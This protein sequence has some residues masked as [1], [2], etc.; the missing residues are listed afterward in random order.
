MKNTDPVLAVEH[1]TTVFDLSTGPAPAVDA[2]SFQIRAGET[3][4]LV[5]ESGSG[6]SVTALSI[7]R[8]VEP[9]GRIT[10][11]RVR[12]KG[13]DL[14]AL[15]ESEMREVRG[16]DI[17]LIFQEPMTALNPVFTIG[18]QIAETLVVHGRSTWRAAMVHAVEL[19]EAVRIPDAPSHL[20]DYPHQLSGGMRQR[21][22]IAMALACKPS[23]VIADEPTTALD[24][25][26]QAQI[27]DLLREMKSAFN[28][29]LLFITH[30]LGVIAETADRVAIM[31][32]G[33]IVEEG[34]VRSILRDPKH[35]YTRGLLASIPGGV[36]GERLRAI[37]GSVPA[38]GALPPGCAFNPRCPDRFE[39]C[40]SAPPPE[41]PVDPNHGA[42]CY[43][44][45]PGT[46]HRPSLSELRPGSPERQRREGGQ[47]PATTR[48]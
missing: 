22:L 29:S 19:L 32:A 10:G 45:D 36:P 31:Y 17:A 12:F 35:P 6:K 43:L 25:T 24:V 38:L 40:T 2:V 28:L 9:P 30:D 23:L 44:Y 1:L 11:G 21:V 26:I 39:P 7:M 5:G 13:R 42:R 47:P 18:D 8:L 37:E 20:N 15:A 34:P 4:G 16:A 46:S 3:L 27:L 33:R 48:R 14:L 41:Y